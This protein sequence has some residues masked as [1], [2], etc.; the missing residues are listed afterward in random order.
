M[1]H[2]KKIIFSATQPSGKITLGNYL[3]AL[4]NWVSLQEDY[5]ALY[6]VADEHAITV[7]QD[8]A[9]L[10][11]QALC[12]PSENPPYRDHHLLRRLLWGDHRGKQHLGRPGSDE[13]GR[14]AHL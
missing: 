8:P 1:E 6:C 5:H 9:A 12:H 13:A 2:E 4:R 10:R 3:G 11:R 7:R 14:P